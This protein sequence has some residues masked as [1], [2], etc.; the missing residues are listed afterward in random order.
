VPAS[1]TPHASS[2]GLAPPWPQ[3]LT[4]SSG[5]PLR[6]PE[7]AHHGLGGPR[8]CLDE[9]CALDRIQASAPPLS[10]RDPLE[11]PHAEV[12]HIGHAC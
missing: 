10:E 4:T 3:T 5:G 6:P 7:I 8:E 2:R 1:E 11:P 9:P 12:R